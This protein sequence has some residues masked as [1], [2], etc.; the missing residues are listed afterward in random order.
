MINAEMKVD[1][2]RTFSGINFQVFNPQIDEI[3]IEDIAHAL[4][5]LCRYG[6][7]SNQFYTVAQHSIAASYLVS[8]ENAMC[9]LMHDSTEAYLCD[10]PRPI[11][12]K[13]DN[14]VK[15]ENGLYEVISQKFELPNPM[16]KEIHQID[17]L[18]ITEF[19]WDYFMINNPQEKYIDFYKKFFEFTSFGEIKQKFLDRF[20]EIQKEDLK[21]KK[22]LEIV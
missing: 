11:K 18:M 2:I 22:K 10:I 20:L 8:P 6:G 13:L 19:E 17:A 1:Y 12:H 15:L 9:A 14:Y 4:S 7:H 16:P 5:H 3:L 21:F